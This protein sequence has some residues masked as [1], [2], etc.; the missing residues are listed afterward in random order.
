MSKK[1]SEALKRYYASRT[2]EQRREQTKKAR[3]GCQKY[4]DDM[5]EWERK[6]RTKEFQEIGT[7]A[8]SEKLAKMTPEEKRICLANWIKAGQEASFLTEGPSSEE[9]KLAEYFQSRGLV[10]ERQKEISGFFVDFYAHSK[11][12]VI[13]YN[14]CF[15]H[16]CEQCGFNSGYNDL[17]A[18]DVRT[19]NTVRM[20]AI[21]SQGYEV[22]VI[23]GHDLERIINAG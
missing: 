17:T 20:A 8:M 11:N 13:E 14:G 15:W 19:Y 9:E 6:E 18:E 4:W 7:A 12:I 23:W 3:E 2:P 16:Q 5:P 10:F 22:R 21:T 1:L